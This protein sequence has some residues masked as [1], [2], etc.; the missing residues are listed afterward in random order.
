MACSSNATSKPVALQRLSLSR[1]VRTHN[2]WR[3]LM[4]SRAL[5]GDLPQQVVFRPGKVGDFHDHLRPHPVERTTASTASRSDYHVV[6][7][8]E[9]VSALEMELAPSEVEGALGQDDGK[10]RCNHRLTPGTT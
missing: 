9:K 7:A 8:G 1:R 5:M 3:R 4:L 2:L 6:A 10:G